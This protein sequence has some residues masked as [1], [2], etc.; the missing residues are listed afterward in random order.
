MINYWTV[1][2]TVQ[3]IK[4]P[5]FIIKNV[6]QR[7]NLTYDDL[8]SEANK[9]KNRKAKGMA[10]YLC[11]KMLRYKKKGGI[12]IKKLGK[13]FNVHHST[14]IHHL[15]YVGRLLSAANADGTKAYQ[16]YI[17]EVEFLET[18]ITSLCQKKQLK[19]KLD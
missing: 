16:D 15:R 17:A 11:A 9:K 18:S 3:L 2:G 13:A 12:T 10:I 14:C 1:P 4:S 5:P 7:F 6:A 8:T 19:S